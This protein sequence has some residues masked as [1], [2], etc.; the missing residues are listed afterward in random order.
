MVKEPVHENYISLVL[1]YNI[2]QS[3]TTYN[4]LLTLNATADSSCIL[5]V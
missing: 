1:R 4:A 3:Q 5:S 2:Y